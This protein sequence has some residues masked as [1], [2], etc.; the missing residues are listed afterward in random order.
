MKNQKAFIWTSSALVALALVVVSID[1]P[2]SKQLK[3]GGATD[4]TVSWTSANNPFKT[5]NV[6]YYGT[7]DYLDEANFVDSD[8]TSNILLVYIGSY[9]TTD[10]SETNNYGYYGPV[11]CGTG[12]D[13]YL[14][15]AQVGTKNSGDGTN[16]YECSLIISFGLKG[17]TSVSYSLTYSSGIVAD[18][19]DIEATFS[20]VPNFDYT[21]PNAYDSF[22]FTSTDTGTFPTTGTMTKTT[23]GYNGLWAQIIISAHSASANGDYIQLNSLSSTHSC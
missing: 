9:Y 10:S 2:F 14:A 17:L 11:A 18:S 22:T 13:G 20:E 5:E 6:K 19:P 21:D 4:K 23:E 1:N 15:R 12:S 7:N 3:A 8:P 16:D